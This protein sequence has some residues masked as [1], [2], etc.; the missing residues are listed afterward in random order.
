[1]SISKI[2]DNTKFVYPAKIEQKAN[3]V[4]EELYAIVSSR[5]K[6]EMIIWD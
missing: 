2:E 1:V 4:Y 5:L 6:G 3:F